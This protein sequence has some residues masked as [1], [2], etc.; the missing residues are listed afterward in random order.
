MARSGVRESGFL[1]PVYTCA[2]DI[3]TVER[4]ARER[5]EIMAPNI[6]LMSMVEGTLGVGKGPASPET[7]FVGAAHGRRRQIVLARTRCCKRGG[8]TTR[9]AGSRLAL[10]ICRAPQCL[11]DMVEPPGQWS[12][13]D[14]ARTECWP[15]RSDVKGGGGGCCSRS[16][17]PW[18]A[19]HPHAA[20]VPRASLVVP[21]RLSLSR[22]LRQW[23]ARDSIHAFRSGHF[24]RRHGMCGIVDARWQ[25]AASLYGAAPPHEESGKRL[26]AERQLATL[27]SYGTRCRASQS[28]RSSSRLFLYL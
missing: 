6:F 8:R 3:L 12:S 26:D 4:G 7:V 24:G 21:G 25:V 1:F 5:G 16:S 13:P 15:R 22:G 9:S 23:P 2:I 28:S 11:I 18:L 20:V 19:Q 14:A 17:V 27:R 10:E